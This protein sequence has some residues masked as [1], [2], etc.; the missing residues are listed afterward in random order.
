MT[1]YATPN[2]IYQYPNIY[3]YIKT[4][5]TTKNILFVKSRKE[6]ILFDK[7]KFDAIYCLPKFIKK[8]LTYKNYILN[9][10]YSIPT[11]T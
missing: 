9:K 11:F 7:S 8:K 2:F 1:I 4:I 3:K 10:D 5:S 6:L